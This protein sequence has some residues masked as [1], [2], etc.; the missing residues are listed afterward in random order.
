MNMSCKH[1]VQ[2]TL[3]SA[4]ALAVTGCGSDSN[5]SAGT[6]SASTSNGNTS[7]GTSNNGGSTNNGGGTQGSQTPNALASVQS[8][9]SQLITA[10]ATPFAGTPLQ[11]FV[12]C[13]D[14]TLNQLLTGPGVLLGSLQASS[15]NPQALQA[16]LG[17][18]GTALSTSIQSLTV[19]L[20]K[21]LLALAGQG[22]CATG[23]GSGS[24][25]NPLD[26]LIATLKGGVAGT[27]LAALVNGLPSSGSG[28]LTGTPL[29]ALLIPLQQLATGNTGSASQGQLLDQVGIALTQVGTSLGQAGQP[30]QGAP[31]AGPLVTTLATTVSDLG[32]TLNQLENVQTANDLQTTVNDLLLN[33]NNLLTGR[34]GLLGALANAAG[35]YSAVQP[36]NA[37]LNSG[38]T[39]ATMTLGST[40]LQP[41]AGQGG[42]LP[43]LLNALQP[44]TCPLMLVGNCT[45]S[46]AKT[47]VLVRN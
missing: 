22:S 43:T 14:P 37:A 13:L 41:L 36:L 17:T 9:V 19:N 1:L 6:T 2:L 15:G 7:G 21:A 40:L 11:N 26:Q 34:Q 31:V 10:A 8:Q 45:V 39:Q 28:S 5:T 42:L 3:C 33:V 47:A 23:S 30:A 29:D 4:L 46:A 20:P 32:K 25:G 27:P 16:A 38:I 18:S 35:Q 24:S 44:L 12:L